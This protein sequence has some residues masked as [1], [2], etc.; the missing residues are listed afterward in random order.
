M[1]VSAPHHRAGHARLPTI[2]LLVILAAT[3][4]ALITAN[5]APA[6]ESLLPSNATAQ[7]DA[8]CAGE[9]ACGGATAY[10]P[11]RGKGRTHQVMCMRAPDPTHTR[12]L[13]VTDTHVA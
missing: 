3:V 9:L 11:A 12:T 7:Q 8:G 6:A 4:P 5:A 1:A 2:L 10:A 13:L